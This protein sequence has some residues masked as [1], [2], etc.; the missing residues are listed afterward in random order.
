MGV[1]RATVNA[2][3]DHLGD[4][5]EGVGVHGEGVQYHVYQNRQKYCKGSIKPEEDK[6]CPIKPETCLAEAVFHDV[7]EDCAEGDRDGWD[8][9]RFC[10]VGERCSEGV[11]IQ[12]KS[13]QDHRPYAQV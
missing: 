13:C 11:W 3:V 2:W 1:M 4:V 8:E 5:S 12:I 9:E 7:D 10:W 6:H